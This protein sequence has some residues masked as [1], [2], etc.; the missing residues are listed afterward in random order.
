MLGPPVLSL[1]GALVL[2]PWLC[3]GI[4]ATVKRCVVSPPV[5]PAAYVSPAASMNLSLIYV[6]V[7][8]KSEAGLVL[9]LLQ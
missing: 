2:P 6:H 9:E 8:P 1:L 3:D 7:P 4:S 5:A